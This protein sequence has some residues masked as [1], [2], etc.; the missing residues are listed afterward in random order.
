MSKFYR[1][2]LYSDHWKKFRSMALE[3]YGNK[4]MQCG[5]EDAIFDIHHLTYER[6]G[7]ELFDDVAVLCRDCHM[8]LH[9]E[10]NKPCQHEKKNRGTVINASGMHFVY[11]CDK[12][13]VIVSK[14]KPTEKELIKREK[15]LKRREKYAIEE[16]ARQAEKEE[17]LKKKAQ[18]PAPK[19]RK[20]TRHTPEYWAKRRASK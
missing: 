17:R 7:E 2:Y 6:L 14:R 18:K 4:C 13:D 1:A 5:T 15:F 12:C 19:K 9:A 8:A 16:A 3:Y 11:F 20:R 10:K